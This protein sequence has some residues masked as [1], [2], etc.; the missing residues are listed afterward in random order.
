MPA[1]LVPLVVAITWL[2]ASWYILEMVQQLLFGRRR[3]DL[4]YEDLHQS[5]F[6]AIL[7]VVL[8]VIALGLA[9]T[10][11]FGSAPQPTRAGAVGKAVIWNR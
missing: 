11:L 8:I 3:W 1:R 4:R 9:P 10:N 5:E 2:T 6:A 7:M